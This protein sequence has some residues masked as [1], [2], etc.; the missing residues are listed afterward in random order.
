MIN[1][2]IFACHQ[3]TLVSIFILPHPYR[4]RTTLF[5]H[6]TYEKEIKVFAVRILIY[7]QFSK[8]QVSGNRQLPV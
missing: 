2:I 7:F 5:M 1:E 8:R 6:E 4:R 3:R